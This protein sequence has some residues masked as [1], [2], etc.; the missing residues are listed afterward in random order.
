LVGAEHGAL[1]EGRSKALV[2]ERAEVDVTA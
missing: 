1:A 2:E